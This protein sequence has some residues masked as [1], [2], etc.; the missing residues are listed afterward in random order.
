LPGGWSAPACPTRGMRKVTSAPEPGTTRGTVSQTLKALASKG[1]VTEAASPRD[2]R[3]IS[4]T[5]TQTGRAHLD[6][7][8]ALADAA[9]R[10]SPESA[11]AAE[12]ALTDLLRVLLARRGQR[13]FGICGTCRHHRPNP[14][15]SAT[16]ALLSVP[17]APE[18]T[19]LLCIEHAA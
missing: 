14:D 15:R 17:L 2:R 10:L 16:C 7:P 5:L 9:A 13:A 6:R 4:Y 1:L 8:S 18:E 11:A 3:S 19:S 12:T